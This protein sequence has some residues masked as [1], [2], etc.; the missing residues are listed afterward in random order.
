[1]YFSC[2]HDYHPFGLHRFNK[3][4]GERRREGVDSSCRLSWADH[5]DQPSCLSFSTFFFH[6]FSVPLLTFTSFTLSHWS[7]FCGGPLGK[8]LAVPWPALPLPA[9]SLQ[10][11]LSAFWCWAGNE[12]WGF[13]QS[14]AAR[15]KVHESSESEQKQQRWG[16]SDQNY[17]IKVIRGSPGRRPAELVIILFQ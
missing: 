1:M 2:I 8:V 9:Y 10:L 12:Q 16:P 17:E 6:L 7:N 15:V 4:K 14:F 13:F 5:N 3:N 11:C